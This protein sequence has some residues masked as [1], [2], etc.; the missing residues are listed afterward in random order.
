MSRK[1]SMEAFFKIFFEKRNSQVLH[2]FFD[3]QTKQPQTLTHTKSP[4]LTSLNSRQN[5]ILKL[6]NCELGL[7]IFF[8]N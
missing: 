2:I 6:V 1:L 5:H 3:L 8:N 7:N 4:D